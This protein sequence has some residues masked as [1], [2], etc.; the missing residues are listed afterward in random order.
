M[1]Q[2]LRPPCHVLLPRLPSHAFPPCHSRPHQLQVPSSERQAA[3]SSCPLSQTPRSSARSRA[4]WPSLPSPARRGLRDAPAPPV[5]QRGRQLSLVSASGW[6]SRGSPEPQASWLPTCPPPSLLPPAAALP[7][8]PADG[9]TEPLAL[10]RCSPAVQGP[11]R[12]RPPAATGKARS[13]PCRSQGPLP[14]WPAPH[15]PGPAPPPTR[16]RLD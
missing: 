13:F 6:D 1:R 7:A 12:R 10:H 3:S 16:S 4:A 14:P 5:A 2:G 9:Q 11:S 15:S 8:S